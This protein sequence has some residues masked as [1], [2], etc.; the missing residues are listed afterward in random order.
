MF[1]E[2]TIYVQQ[3]A[4]ESLI[5]SRSEGTGSR[6]WNIKLGREDFVDMGALFHYVGFNVLT[7]GPQNY[8]NMLFLEARP[9]Y[10]KQRL[11][12]VMGDSRRDQKT[13]RSEHTIMDLYISLEISMPGC[14]LWKGSEDSA[15]TNAL[16]RE[17][18]ASLRSSTVMVIQS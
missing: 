1:Q 6:R 8:S 4:G 10:M 5:G 18:E 13:N 15:M 14:A 7:K 16:V 12:T 9:H 11:Q 17:V 2:H 3:Q